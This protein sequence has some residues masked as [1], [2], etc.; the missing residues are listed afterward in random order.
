MPSEKEIN[1]QLFDQL[2]IV[3]RIEKAAKEDNAHKTMEQCRE[4]RRMIER[5]LYQ[6]PE[7]IDRPE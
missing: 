7:K 1:N 3:E 2:A 5:K 6:N 4:E